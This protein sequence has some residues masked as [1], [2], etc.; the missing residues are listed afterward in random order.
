[1]SRVRDEP[2]SKPRDIRD[3][4]GVPAGL[5][6][7]RSGDGRWGPSTNGDPTLPRLDLATVDPAW[8]Q[9]VT[10]EAWRA[11]DDPEYGSTTISVGQVDGVRTCVR[12]VAHEDDRESRVDVDC[13]GRLVG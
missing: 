4:Q 3:L 8:V 13:R 1:L 12:A 5:F 7:P 9:H 11:L 6:R 2:V 10:D